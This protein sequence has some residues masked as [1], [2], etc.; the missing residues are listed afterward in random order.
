MI[1]E[2]KPCPFCGD[3]AEEL[4]MKRKKLF[5]KLCFPYVTHIVYIRCKVC[6]AT[7]ATKW[8]RENAI[9]AWNKRTPQKGGAE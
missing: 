1:A 4:Y 3:E 7:S 6:A 2:L 8:T 9:E 5:G